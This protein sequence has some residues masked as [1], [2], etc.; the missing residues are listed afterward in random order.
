VQDDCR[1]LA[2]PSTKVFQSLSELM[3]NANFNAFVAEQQGQLVTAEEALE[4][5][6]DYKNVHDMLHDLQFKCYNYIFQEARKVEDQIDWSLLVQ[7]Q[8][9]LAEILQS[10]EYAANRRSMADE[11]F[12]LANCA[13][14][15]ATQRGVR[16][17]QPSSAQDCG[18]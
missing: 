8:K 5:L 16:P 18:T 12:W 17:A 7:P 11:D 13:A 6:V 1:A 9:D 2:E 3:I 15:G 10:L 4:V 14:L